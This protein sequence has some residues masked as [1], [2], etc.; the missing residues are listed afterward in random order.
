[1][2]NRQYRQLAATMYKSRQDQVVTESRK[3]HFSNVPPGAV[4]VGLKRRYGKGPLYS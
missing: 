2:V 1:M 4:D 3:Y